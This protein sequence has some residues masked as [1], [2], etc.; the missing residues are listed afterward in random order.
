[1][2]AEL[3]SWVRQTVLFIC[4]LLQLQKFNTKMMQ[5]KRVNIVNEAK[6]GNDMKNKYDRMGKDAKNKYEMG[7][8]A[9]T[10]S[11]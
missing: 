3:H 10:Y 8:D 4:T 2:C 6:I 5:N 7:K 11:K 9:S 1:V